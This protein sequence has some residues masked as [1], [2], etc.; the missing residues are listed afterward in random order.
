MAT[1]TFYIL[2]GNDDLRLEE[3][4]NKFRAQMGDSPNA[5]MNIA[6]FDGQSASVAEIL[7]A[8]TSFPF[9]ADRRLIIVRGLISWVTRKGAG[10]T[11]KQAVDKLINDLPQLPDWSR[12]VLV[13]RDTLSATNK[14]V[15]LAQQ[16]PAGFEKSFTTPKDSTSWIMQ[17][18]KEQYDAEIDPRA[19]QALA[20]VTGD[21][22]RRADNELI[23]LV[24][25]VDSAR[26][27]TED[28]VA[29]LT[30]YVAEANIFAMVDALALGKGDVALALLHRLLEDSPR[31]EGFGLYGMI[32]RQF[33]LL[34]IA[35]EHLLLNGGRQ[36]LPEALG[37]RSKFVADKAADQSRN[38]TLEQLEDIYRTLQDYDLRIKTGRIEP[39]LALDLL[40]AGL[41]RQP[42]P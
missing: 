29:E 20:S 32:V 18:A 38:F 7:N 1:K 22:L 24:S 15:K 5:D 26:P 35:K 14:L 27:I 11:G 17:R 4:V 25:Y 13:E 30:P 3:E 12:V 28:D 39:Q 31:D 21:D 33:R 19:A 6:E 10:E 36:G 41:S 16:E 2:H 37:T 42:G 9:L 8:A 40:V 23:K 34:L